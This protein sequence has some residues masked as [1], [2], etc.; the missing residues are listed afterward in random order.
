M[1]NIYVLQ[2]DETVRFA[3][4]ELAHYLRNMTGLPF[5]IEERRAWQEAE[6]ALWLGTMCRFEPLRQGSG[7]TAECIYIDTEGL[8]GIIG[9]SNAG[10]VLLAVYRYLTELGCRWLKP[11]HAGEYVPQRGGDVGAVRVAESPSYRCRGVCIEGAVSYENVLEMVRWLPK[12]GLN[13]YF[14]QFREAYVF[15]ERWYRHKNHVLKENNE[16]F[17]VRDAQD[18]ARAIAAEIKKR[19]LILHAVGHGWTCESFGIPGLGWDVWDGEIAPSTHAYFALVNGERKLWGGVPVNTSICFANREA[20]RRIVQEVCAYAADHPEIDILHLWL[21][22]GADNQCECECCWDDRPSDQY[23]A[24]LNEIDAEMTSRRLET[25]LA[26]IAYS[27]TLWPPVK[28]NLWN[29]DRFILL[30]APITRSFRKSY[31]SMGHPAPAPEYTKNRLK[32]PEPLE[33]NRALLNGWRQVFDGEVCLYDYH[34]MWAHHKDPGYWHIAKV[35]H[36]DVAALGD[37]RLDGMISCQVQRSFFPNGLAM[38]TLARTL[39]DKTVDFEQLADEYCKATY[40]DEW[41]ACRMYL[42]KLSELY[43]MLDFSLTPEEPS[44][45]PSPEKAAV[46]DTIVEHIGSFRHMFSRIPDGLTAGQR[47]SWAILQAHGNI[48]SDITGALRYIYSGNGA[49]AKEMWAGVKLRL[50]ERED[51]DQ[52]SL[53]VYNFVRTMDGLFADERQTRQN[54]SE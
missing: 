27:D 37:M 2:G 20:V 24:L 46:C 31:A 49:L 54:G 1:N 23:V 32:P 45:T 6:Q 44:L 38:I 39:W 9:G 13:S 43:L 51:N 19:G 15:F 21:S 26:F 22:D 14:I 11:G 30:F 28:R 3:A 48:W 4:C 47:E 16:P 53:D 40:G 8:S 17:D 34:M 33:G 12:V 5:G 29:Q 41:I 35:L 25:R 10:S 42:Q 52:D 7:E 18:Y 36:G 50:A